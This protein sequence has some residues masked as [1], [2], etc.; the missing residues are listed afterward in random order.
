MPGV[1]IDT[2]VVPE[3]FKTA[4]LE[5]AKDSAGFLRTLPGFVEGHIHEKMHGD[6]VHDI[7]TTAVGQGQAAFE[8]AKKKSGN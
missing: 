5:K 6:G 2:F 3:S 7:V 8:H 1:L 4:L